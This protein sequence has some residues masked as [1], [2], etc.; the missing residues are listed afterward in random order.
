MYK[1]WFEKIL[2][3]VGITSIGLIDGFLIAVAAILIHCSVYSI[4]A[5]LYKLDIISGK[6]AGKICYFVIWIA[7]LVGCVFLALYCQR[8]MI[9]LIGVVAVLLLYNFIYKIVKHKFKA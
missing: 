1:N 5:F 9:V 4:V 8:N 2:G 6:I 3:V 7:S